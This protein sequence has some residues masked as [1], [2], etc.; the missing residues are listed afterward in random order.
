MPRYQDMHQPTLPAWRSNA[1]VQAQVALAQAGIYGEGLA[2]IDEIK[3]R[4]APTDDDEDFR[5]N[6]L[7]SLGDA[8][9]R[10]YY[11][12]CRALGDDAMVAL[13]KAGNARANFM[14]CQR[15]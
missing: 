8:I 3:A 12:H 4:C 2:Q 9:W 6:I 7:I 14:L 13:D 11:L 5:D 1:Q 15:R 10:A